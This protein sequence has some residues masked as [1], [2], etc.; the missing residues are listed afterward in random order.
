LFNVRQDI[1]E[2]RD[3]TSARPILAKQLE[4]AWRAWEK[5]NIEIRPMAGKEAE[6]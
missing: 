3:R 6:H 2:S 5:G 1:S 4:E